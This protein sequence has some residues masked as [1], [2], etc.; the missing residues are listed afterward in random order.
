MRC[1]RVLA[2]GLALIWIGAGAAASAQTAADLFDASTF[3]KVR[4]FMISRDLQQLREHYTEPT[5]STGDVLWRDARVRNASV[6]SR[7][8]GTANPVKPGLR[9][10]FVRYTSGQ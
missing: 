8:T 4:L 1:D 3:N 6:R 9:I 2:I 5:R 7:G 10:Y